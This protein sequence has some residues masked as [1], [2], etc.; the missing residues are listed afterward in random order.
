MTKYKCY[1]NVYKLVNYISAQEHFS[2][3]VACFCVL[4]LVSV[5]ACFC[6]LLP[7]VCFLHLIVLCTTGTP[8]KRNRAN[9]HQTDATAA[10]FNCRVGGALF[11]SFNYLIQQ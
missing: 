9:A 2:C 6:V 3:V 5:V 7:F 1:V 10:A 11:L 4:W 8:H